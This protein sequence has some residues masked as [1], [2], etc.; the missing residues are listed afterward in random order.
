MSI[1]HVLYK[2]ESINEYSLANLENAQLYFN[3]PDSF[4]DP[5]DCSLNAASFTYTDDDLVELYNYLVTSGN[6]GKAKPID[7]V[8]GFPEV[9]KN[10][11][12]DALNDCV[13]IIEDRQKNKLGCTCFTKN[14]SHIL[15][16]AHYAKSHKGMCLE[17]DST[18]PPFNR[19]IEVAYCDNFPEINPI[20]IITKSNVEL[21]NRE[22]LK[23]LLTKYSCWAYEAEW[24]LFHVESNKLFG[25]PPEAL[26]AVY[27]GVDVSESDFEAVCSILD[28]HHKGIKIYRAEKS[29][30]RYEINFIPLD[31]TPCLD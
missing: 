25:Y 3:A 21:L 18:M 13:K 20:N 7:N 8:K 26:R 22:S 30:F 15:M 19:A 27:F 12:P 23:P 29:K 16:W 5:F 28:R 6:L 11:I 17:F 14:N 10:Q 4:N 1:H 31:Y 9:L 2:Y 24:R